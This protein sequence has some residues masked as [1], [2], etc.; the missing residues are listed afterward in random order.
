MTRYAPSLP[1]IP[2]RRGYKAN[3]G[4]VFNPVQL[5]FERGP[6]CLE[7]IESVPFCNWYVP[8]IDD[9]GLACRIGQE[10]AAHFVQNLKDDP[11]VAPNNILA[12]IVRDIDFEDES[13]A[14]GYWI[15]FFTQL[16]SYLLKGAQHIDVF[17]ELDKDIAE[18]E[19]MCADD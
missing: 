16:S 4:K 2:K 10:Y 3:R 7:E 8:R 9:I 15:G 11:S 5:P 18:E 12:D 19:R 1:V 17:A 6:R 13:D 14:K